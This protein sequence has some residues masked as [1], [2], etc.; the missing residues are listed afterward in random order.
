MQMMQQHQQGIIDGQVN[1]GMS[2]SHTLPHNLSNQRYRASPDIISHQ[3]TT[4]PHGSHYHP[5]HHNAHQPQQHQHHQE[6]IHQHYNTIGRMPTQ[7]HH[8]GIIVPLCSRLVK[9]L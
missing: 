3:V 9:M 6:A 2:H 8:Q 4:R 5:H 1:G 7:H